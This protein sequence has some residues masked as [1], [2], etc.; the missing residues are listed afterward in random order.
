MTK[1]SLFFGGLALLALLV[2]AG[3]SNPSSSD[4]ESSPVAGNPLIPRDAVLAGDFDQ[5]VGLLNEIA[6]D[7]N[8]VVNIAYAGTFDGKL[9]IRSGKTVYLVASEANSGVYG[10][11]TDNVI[12]E[13]GA[14]L[15]VLENVTL[16]T[17]NSAS[18]AGRL[19]VKGK[20]DVYG[21]LAVGLNALDVAD[22]FV[23][24]DTTIEAR[25]T[26][27]GTNRI[28]I[29]AGGAL[30]LK[31]DDIANQTTPDRFTPT[32]AWAAA[33]QGHLTIDG[34]LP[35]VYTVTY[36]LEGINPSA[37][38]WYTFE[39]AGGEVPKLI[40]VG[41]H[42]TTNAAIADTTDPE[43]TLTVNG[44]LIANNASLGAVTQITVSGALDTD[45]AANRSI[46]PGYPDFYDW[47]EGY[48]EANGATL[49][50][51][52]SINVLDR[53]EF[54]SSSTA[55][56][57]PETGTK[58]NLGRSA[59][60]TASGAA[61]N[62]FENLTDLY[63]GPGA[64]VKIDSPALTFGDLRTLTLQDGARL[65]AIG[66]AVTFL[67]EDPAPA[68]P[69]KTQI[70][71]GLNS[72]Y[73]V[74]VSPTAKVAVAIENNSK[75]IDGSTLTVN[76][77]S[78]LSLAAGKTLTVGDGAE[79]DLSG[80][81][82]TAQAT[83]P[84]SP[85]AAPVQINGEIK[86]EEG[87]TLKGPD[88]T[89]L[90]A[91]ADARLNAAKFF[92]FG[93]DGKIL[94]S[95]GAS[96][97]MGEIPVVGESTSG[98]TWVAA[99]SAGVDAQIEI[100][101]QG[102][103]IRDVKKG[104]GAAKV[105][106]AGPGAYILKG[107]T[108]TLEHSSVKLVSSSAEGLILFGGDTTT[109]GATLKGPGKLI[110]SKDGTEDTTTIVGGAY[111]WQAVGAETIKFYY[112]SKSIIAGLTALTGAAVSAETTLKAMGP[113]AAIAQAGEASNDLNVGVFT[114]IALGGTNLVEHGAIILK[115]TG[116]DASNN[117]SMSLTAATSK[118][119]TGNTAGTG[120]TAAVKLDAEGETTISGSAID[121]HG[122]LL[123]AGDGNNLKATSTATVADSRASAGKLVSLE[124]ASGATV[125]CSTTGAPTDEASGD[126]IISSL[127]Q[128]E[129]SS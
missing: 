20:V 37:T 78:T 33:G 50:S 109:D 51:A 118:I 24:A 103:I 30:S 29:G 32:Q 76:E 123:L 41:A 120:Q 107:Q 18:T 34:E 38:R 13:E 112:S 95:Y 17:D 70:T 110:I 75:L 81:I 2:F 91:T 63:I 1:R 102:V 3:C 85:E 68:T 71:L 111:G 8:G 93:E 65:D 14:R 88:V 55:I 100:N 56:E 90:G 86:L 43:H 62:S 92:T 54:F 115:N 84:T 127:T 19:L 52:A 36:M 42:V 58:I 121:Q 128:T 6:A 25:G 73:K 57:L 26:V 105:A 106:I 125:K 4:P 10:L 61:T 101:G 72:F 69:N 64:G 53:G 108:L 27:I 48:L 99:A 39:T 116:S 129:A 60:F 94:L 122:I 117:G 12:V 74:G 87:G 22:Y 114:T 49:K 82:T 59:T 126:A 28:A 113:G 7:T 5:L 80:L 9:T 21:T 31:D 98:Y 96:Y 89:K 119:T 15:V 35:S 66:G 79:V 77:G 47:S 67:V 23:A 11:T 45:N 83:V 44:W 46:N 104:T 124:G 40:P 97:L 16:S